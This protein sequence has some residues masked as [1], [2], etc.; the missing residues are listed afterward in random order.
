MDFLTKIYKCNF[1]NVNFFCKVPKL[2]IHT[3]VG[4]NS[5]ITICQPKLAQLNKLVDGNM[6]QFINKDTNPKRKW[7]Y[8]EKDL[9]SC[10]IN[11]S[12]TL[13]IRDRRWSN[14]LSHYQLLVTRQQWEWKMGLEVE[15][16]AGIM[17]WFVMFQLG[18]QQAQ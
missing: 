9:S 15:N 11:I 10:W 1:I 13:I 18:T 16:S 5:W 8:K 4:E 12:P 3:F 17:E 14:T 2:Y 6:S 7:K